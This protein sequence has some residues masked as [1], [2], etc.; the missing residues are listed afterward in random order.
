M[1]LRYYADT[2]SLYIDLAERPSAD[3]RE[4]TPGIVL[5]FDAAGAL[6]GI[7]IDRASRHLDLSGLGT[8]SIPV[9]LVGTRAH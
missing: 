8:G 4:V 6:V 3:S 5:D 9:E 2:D 7:D 1:R